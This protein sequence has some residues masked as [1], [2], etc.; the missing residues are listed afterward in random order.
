MFRP[1]LTVASVQ[2]AGGVLVI[3]AFH[4]KTLL[5]VRVRLIMMLA[6]VAMVAAVAVVAA[7]Q[8]R[9]QAEQVEAAPRLVVAMVA[10][11]AVAVVMVAVAVLTVVV[12]RLDVLVAPA[13]PR[14]PVKS[15]VTPT[16]H[17]TENPAPAVVMT[18]PAANATNAMQRL[19]VCRRR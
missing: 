5:G 3:F 8:T 11:V 6:A 15:F 13:H 10:A 1:V 16:R 12:G 4:P 9:F 19:S 2:A 14:I 18:I 7:V 17:P